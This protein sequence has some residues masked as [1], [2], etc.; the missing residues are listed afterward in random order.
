MTVLSTTR[1]G[2]TFF[3]FYIVSLPLSHVLGTRGKVWE[4]YGEILA[5][6]DDVIAM[7]DSTEGRK[8][9][10]DGS[11]RVKRINWLATLKPRWREGNDE[12]DGCSDADA[13]VPARTK[14]RMP[15]GRRVANLVETTQDTGNVG[16]VQI[17]YLL[18]S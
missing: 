4:E 8:R 11:I 18:Q 9:E 5:P 10:K 1:Y 12:G 2:H 6:D 15:T 13:C 7:L 17:Q 14:R 16:A 3:V